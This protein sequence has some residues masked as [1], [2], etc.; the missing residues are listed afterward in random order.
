[1]PRDAFTLKIQREF[2]C[3]KSFGTF[4][5]RAPGGRFSKDPVTYRARKALLETMIRLPWKAA[6]LVCFIYKERQNNCQVSKLETCSHW[7]YKGICVTRKGFGTFEKRAAETRFSKAPKLFGGCISGDII[8]SVSSKGRRLEARN[9]AVIL[10]FI[11]FTT[12]EKT[13]FIERA[14]CGLMSSFSGR[15]CFRD[16]G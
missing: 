14:G 13:S 10:I 5:K 7:R 9:F 3:P 16:F 4:E 2:S 11:P 8:I 6:L 1:M 12:F 15:K